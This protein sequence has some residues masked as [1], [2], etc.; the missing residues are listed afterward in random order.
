VRESRESMGERR[1][2]EREQRREKRAAA[3]GTSSQG[4]VRRVLGFGRWAPS[5][6]V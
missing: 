5:G 3:A 6:P 2:G 4:G 1:L